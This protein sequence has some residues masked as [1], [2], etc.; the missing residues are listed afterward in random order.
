MREERGFQEAGRILGDYE[1]E[2]EMVIGK[3]VISQI[4]QAI[5]IITSQYSLKP[6]MMFG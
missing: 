4:P 5:P 6:D 3:D 2:E 1:D